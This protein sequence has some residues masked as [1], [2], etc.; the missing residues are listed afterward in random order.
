MPYRHKHFD[1]KGQ[2]GNCHYAHLRPE[3]KYLRENVAESCLT[4]HDLPIKAD[5]R[6]LENVARN[7]REKPEVHKVMHSPESCPECHTP[8]GAIQP[9][10]LKTGYPAGNYEV[11][12]A[13]QYAL[14]WQ[15][16]NQALVENPTGAG[17]TQFRDGQRNLHRLHVAELGRGRVCGVC[18]QPHASDRPKLLRDRVRFKAWEAPLTIELTQQGGTCLTP[19]HREMGYSR[20]T[21]N[22]EQ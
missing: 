11:Y 6:T 4:C 9:S 3:R 15:C 18:H 10:L 7:L 2:C 5:Q 16:H 14:C 13:E 17:F 1:P 22:K 19:C 21:A 8:H 12:R 20:Q